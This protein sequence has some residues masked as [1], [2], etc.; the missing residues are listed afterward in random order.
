MAIAP[1]PTWQEQPPA[2]PVLGAVTAA[3]DALASSSPQRLWALGDGEVTEAFALLGRLRASIDAHLVAV[4]A[5]AKDRGLGTGDGW[6]PVDWAR[7]FAPHLP[8][9]TLTDLDTV[10]TAVVA[11]AAGDLRLTPVLDAVTVAATADS[12]TNP[13]HPDNANHAD[14][15]DTSTDHHGDSVAAGEDAAGGVGQGVLPVGKAAQIIRF[16]HSVR[17]LADADHLSELT[18]ITLRAARGHRPLSEQGLATALRRAANELR[19]DRL[20]EH[21]ADLRRAHRS[22]VKGP[23]PLGLSR[24]TLLLDDEG[25]AILD[26]AVDALAKPRKDPDTG[27]LDPRTPAARRADALLDLVTRAISAPDGVP[28]QAKTA[29]IV[30][31]DLH[32]LTRQTRGT[33]RTL[34]AHLLS[35]DTLRRLACD[36]D[37]IPMV[38]G[39]HREVLDQGQTVRLFTPAQTRH[40]WVRD[41]GCTFPGCT[42]PPPWTDAH[43]LI[44]WADGGPTDL[45]N[46]A[47]LCRAHHTVVHRHRYT[48]TV[49]RAPEG[50]HVRWDLVPGAYDHHLEALRQAGAIPRHPPPDV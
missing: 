28:R 47:L 14:H 25:A 50:A 4:L 18:T 30:T 34:G 36:A 40:L 48:A 38:L 42:K 9:R 39:S 16:H 35:T 22:L 46:A 7:A 5:E 20:V 17:G 12:A 2:R 15:A 3:L 37:L 23:G 24:Y 32:T 1:D 44:H 6:G 11:G 19:P 43:H 13:D 45:D 10:A 33:G 49:V 27:V 26:T 41:Q 8:T 21:D 29:L 31:T